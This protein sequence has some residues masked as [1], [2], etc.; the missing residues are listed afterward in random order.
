MPLFSSP[1]NLNPNL[2]KNTHLKYKKNT[3][4]ASNSDSS[5]TNINSNNLQNKEPSINKKNNSKNNSDNCFF[6]LFG[7]KLY[8]DDVLL[9]SLLFILYEEGIDDAEL[10]FSLILLL[11]S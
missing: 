10:F 5:H 3:T 6:E 2:Y 8:F 4:Q 7:L 9:I 1:Y 11:L